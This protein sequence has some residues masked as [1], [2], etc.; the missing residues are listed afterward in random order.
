MYYSQQLEIMK[1]RNFPKM[2]AFAILLVMVSLACTNKKQVED[3]KVLADTDRFYSELSAEKG[4]N[5]SFL[6]MFDSA[7]VILSANQMPIE[8][9][10]AISASL[11]S[12]SDSTFTL[13][14][15]PLFAKMAASGDMGYTYGTYKIT[16]RATDSVTGVGKYATIWQKQKDGKWKAILDTGNPGLGDVK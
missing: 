7:G 12:Q 11:M 8:G 5:A 13:T 14:W 3:S 1:T 9:F 10:E 15:E 16:D 2:F 6:A 4:M